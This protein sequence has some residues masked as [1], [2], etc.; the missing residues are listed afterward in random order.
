[1][2]RSMLASL[3]LLIASVAGAHHS[4]A[5]R[6]DTNQ[7]IVLEGTVI[8]F[9]FTNPHS[10]IQLDV[11]SEEQEAPRRWFLQWLNPIYLA[12]RGYTQETVRPGDRVVVSGNP[13]RDGSA[14]L[15]LLELRRPADGFEYEATVE[16]QFLLIPGQ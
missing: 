6:F 2:S 9:N 13:A 15:R 11:D 3:L 14:L 7:R 4:I 8:E 16:E 5:A 12:R 1:M 10:F